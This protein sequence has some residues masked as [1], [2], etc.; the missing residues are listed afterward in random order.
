MQVSRSAYYDWVCIGEDRPIKEKEATLNAA[1]KKDFELS[2]KT[3]GSRRLT[4]ELM[5]AGFVVGRFK[6]SSL[7][8][9]FNLQARYPKRF[10]ATTDSNHSL[11]VA[12][13][14]LNRG[15]T[16]NA[17]NQV[18]TTDISVPQQAA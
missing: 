10:K 3:Y 9:K 4:Q 7:M 18:W 6:V 14:T 17:P 1:L 8:A 2:K 13:N 5:S 11:E 12:P 16:V 15:F